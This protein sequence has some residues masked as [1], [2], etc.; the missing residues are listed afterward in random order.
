[1]L[2]D[3]IQ[4]NSLLPQIKPGGDGV[5]QLKNL[6]ENNLIYY[7]K[8]IMVAVSILYISLYG[9]LYITS[10]GTE[11]N[12]TEQHDNL[13]WAVI[14]FAVIGLANLSGKVFNPIEDTPGSL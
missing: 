8:W 14:G 4:D 3:V 10:S 13:I 7:V 9:F 11:E 1:M 5:A 6:I 12:I 2:I